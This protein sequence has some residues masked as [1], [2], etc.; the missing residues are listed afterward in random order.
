[1]EDITVQELKA[2]IDAGETLNLIDVR[3]PYE[4]DEFNIGGR[5]VP[6][7]EIMTVLPDFEDQKDAEILVHCRSGKRSDMAKQLLQGMGLTNVRNV[8][9]GILA[10]QEA[11]PAK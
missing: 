2:R 10:W 5:L 7:A 6:L 1:M 11:F 3:E 4:Y 9:G 8:L